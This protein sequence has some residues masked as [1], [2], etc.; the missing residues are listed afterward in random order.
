[1]RRA[2]V[3]S[4]HRDDAVLSAGDYLVSCFDEVVVV[5]IFTESMS[6]WLPL[7]PAEVSAI[8][9][10]EDGAVARDYGFRFI[11]LG[12]ADSSIRGEP[13]DGAATTVDRLLL[14]TVAE[15]LATAL[16]GE[17]RDAML[18]LPAAFGMHPDHCLALLAFVT[19]PRL[20]AWATARRFL[21]FCD[22]PYFAQRVR[23]HAALARL[24]EFG[25]MQRHRCDPVRRRAMVALYASQ[26]AHDFVDELVTR[27]RYERFWSV[28]PEWLDIA[29]AA[30]QIIQSSCPPMPRAPAAAHR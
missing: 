11:D 19:E 15:A 30:F 27:V 20:R 5:N 25:R 7:P 13:W 21:L 26:F 3:V 12:F 9:R 29:G 4:P 1:M 18:F 10:A 8:R 17:Q 23:R 22:Q 14:D 2:L 16:E 24:P 28:A 6:S